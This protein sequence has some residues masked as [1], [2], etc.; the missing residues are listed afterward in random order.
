M[1]G[2]DAALALGTLGHESRLAIFRLLVTAGPHGLPAGRIAEALSLPGPTLSF[3]LS[4]LKNAGVAS[5]RRESRSLIYSAN[6]SVMNSLVAFLTENCCGDASK[7]A[8]ACTPARV[9]RKRPAV[10]AAKRRRKASRSRK[11]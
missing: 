3:H 6:F 7:R 5:C 1:K 4:Q 9:A 10:A 2:K 11:G 8:P